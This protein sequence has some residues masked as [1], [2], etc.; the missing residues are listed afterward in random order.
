MSISVDVRTR[1]PADIHPVDPS[2]FFSRTL[3]ELIAQHQGL[4]VPGAREL[5]CTSFALVVDGSAWTLAFDGSGFTVVP[6]IEGA[7]AVAN[8]TGAELTDLVHDLRTPMTFVTAGELDMPVGDLGNFL[9]WWVVLRSL[10]DRVPVHTSGS[11]TF[12]DRDG[13]PLDLH[14]GFD[15]DA[16][17]DDV[18]HFLGEAGFVH[19]RNVFTEAEMT[20]V[21]A[22]MDAAAPDYAPDDGRS[23]WASTHD[24]KERLVRMMYFQKESPTVRALVADDRMQ[25]IGRL[26]GQV[27]GKPGENPNLVEA[28]VKPIGIVKGI[29]D[30]PW[31]K[32]CS[33]GSHSYRCCSLTV[34]VSVTGADA[35]SGQLRVVAGSHRALIQP[36]FVRRGLDLPQ[37]DLPTAT[38]DVTVHLSCTL[39]MAQPPVTRE[40]R[41]LYTDF[42]FSGPDADDDPGEV[43]IAKVRNQAFKMVSQPPGHLGAAAD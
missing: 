41:V 22:D 38:G 19:L 25:R 17:P 14:R 40:R 18:A 27:H 36:A 3:P 32:D 15:P 16:D 5:D 2:Q 33:L 7:D 9:D 20:A 12:R 11:I 29:S 4:A 24:G 13:T 34:G 6:G 31:H 1:T 35:E 10:L 8:I 21:S 26:T 39:H 23:W 43:K 30:V 42:S 37:I 28:L